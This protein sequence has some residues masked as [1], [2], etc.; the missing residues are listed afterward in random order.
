[1]LRFYIANKGEV[2]KVKKDKFSAN[3]IVEGNSNSNLLTYL[4]KISREEGIHNGVE[5][6]VEV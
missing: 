2:E 1:M 4:S 3:L 5:A 6:G